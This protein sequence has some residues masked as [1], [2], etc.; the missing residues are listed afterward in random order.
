[1]AG[2]AVYAVSLWRTMD[3]LK[4]ILD[5]Y[6]LQDW[7]KLPVEI[8]NMSRDNLPALFTELG[9]TV[10]AEIGV[11]AGSYSLIICEGILK[12]KLYCVDSWTLYPEYRDKFT[13][14][15]MDDALALAISRLQKYDVEFINKFSMEAVK[16]FPDKSLDFV[17]IDANHEYP[18][19]TQDIIHWSKK[20]RSGG[21]VAGHDYYET[22]TV[23][24]RCHVIPA[25]VGYTW[26][27]KIKPWFVV[28]TKAKIEG[29]VRDGKRS[30]MW[31]KP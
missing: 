24:S 31:V 10:G 13:Q 26:A 9:F 19:V 28:G 6:S 16:M 4:Y 3:T 15:K 30:W 25:V 14:K 20:V 27:Y 5:K 2:G 17:Y 18:F 12:L 29:Q 21:V 22:T 1:M 23:D 7:R 11:D 8:P